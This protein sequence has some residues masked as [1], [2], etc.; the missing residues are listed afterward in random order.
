LRIAFSA[1]THKPG[2]WSD[3]DGGR[4]IRQSIRRPLALALALFAALTVLVLV[5]CTT[6][7]QAKPATPASA[8]AADAT[9]K[10]VDKLVAKYGAGERARLERGVRQVRAAW[11]P[12]DGTD[13]DQRELIEADFVPTGAALDGVFS[14]FEEVLEQLD[15]HFREI[16]RALKRHSELDLGPVTSLDKRM[17]ALDPAA[18]LADD[19]FESKIAVSTLVN[20]PLTTLKERL[21]E[22]DKWSRRQW[23][24]ARLAQRFEKRVPAAVQARIQA[25]GAAAALYIAEYNLLMHHVV[26]GST[27]ARPF[28]RGLRLISHWN[29]RDELKAAYAGGK[30]GLT[31]QRMIAKVMERIV[32]QSIPQ[33]VINHA[34]VD[35]DPFTN[36]VTPSP[37]A[38]IEEGAEHGWGSERSERGTHPRAGTPPAQIDTAREP[39]TRYKMLHDAF[40]AQRA[41]DPYWPTAPTYVARSF[42]ILREIP[43][44]RFVAM[45]QEVLTSPL[46]P[47]IAKLIEKR[48]GRP[49]APF[50]LW[51]AGFRPRAKHAEAELDALTRKRYPTAQAYKNDMPRLLEKLGFSPERAR[52]FADH[53]AVDPA[54]G[55]GHAEPA[56]RRGDNPR[57][58]TRV[59]A[60][61]MN[62]KG[63][64]I[65]VHEMGHNVEQVCSLYLVDHTLLSG[66]PNMAFTEA[67]AFVFQ[68]RDLELLGL[69][70]DLASERLKALTDFWETFEIAGVAL[71]DLAVW[72]WM[73]AHPNATPAE[74]RA[75]VVSIARDNWNKYY[76]PI[77]GARDSLLL[78]IYSHMISE[79]LYLPDYPL[80]HIIAAQIE[81]HMRKKGPL[82]A[83]FERMASFGSLTPDV[84][85]KHATGEPVSP[86][87]LLRTAEEA[88][89]QIRD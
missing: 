22:G 88:L 54:R 47:R 81:E 61:G 56:Q 75:A 31:K 32:D 11:R 17:A 24:E 13:R 49:L 4:V 42:D 6:R 69:G 26:D 41:A 20:F 1:L 16:A 48:L 12:A 87:A 67:L 7:A 14:R 74:L 44:A 30:D 71:V 62:Y 64:N 80:G 78:G 33:V 39:D 51:Y 59:E 83:E 66:V 65:A 52:F 85:M 63:Y 84:W 38:E 89:K 53:I 15:G 40:L 45:M 9:A 23:A 72:R 21:D 2:D 29:L 50:D 18:H 3:H 35:W 58:R 55:A 70:R 76:A 5:F 68:A 25:A 60:G 86:R 36:R 79:F 77:F 43:E 73:Y 57:L 19:L 37:A 46:A 8:A 10:L 27:G 82:G 28:P 34:S